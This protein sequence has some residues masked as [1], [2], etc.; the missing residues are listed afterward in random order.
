MTRRNFKT[1]VIVARFKHCGGKCEACGVVL[2]PGGYHADHDNPDGLTGGPTFE[3]CRILC[4][5]CHAMKTKADVANIAQ[6]KRREAK[7]IG[8]VKPK[9]EIKSRGFPEKPRAEKLPIPPRRVDVYGRRV[10]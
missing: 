9:T 3:N 8:A 6:A 2:K 7:A 1:S 5:Q 4:L 10:T